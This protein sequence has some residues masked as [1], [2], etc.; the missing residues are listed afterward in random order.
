VGSTL[1]PAFLLGH[2]DDRADVGHARRDVERG[3]R[4]VGIRRPARAVGNAGG[5]RPRDQRARLGGREAL[6]ARYLARPHATAR[7]AATT[8]ASQRLISARSLQAPVR[9]RE[10]AGAHLAHRIRHRARDIA[11]LFLHRLIAGRAPGGSW[12]TARSSRWRR[13]R[14]DIGPASIMPIQVEPVAQRAA[15]L[16][17]A[18][19]VAVHRHA[20]HAPFEVLRIR[21]ALSSPAPSPRRGPSPWWTWDRDCRRRHTRADRS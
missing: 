20:V 3:H 15:R 14:R 1:N 2:R 13:S 7:S 10:L 8:S 19:D 12:H 11:H 5:N 16:L 4:G 6:L 17:V 9:L 18:R 21:P